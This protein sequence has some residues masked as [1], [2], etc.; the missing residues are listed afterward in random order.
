MRR[1]LVYAFDKP[2]LR[3]KCFVHQLGHMHNRPGGNPSRPS[4]TTVGYIV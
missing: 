1:R 2:D 4:E 3:T